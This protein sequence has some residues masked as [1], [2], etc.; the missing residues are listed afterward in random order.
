MYTLMYRWATRRRGI[1]RLAIATHPSAASIYRDLLQFEQLG[2]VRDYQGLKDAPSMPLAVEIAP[3]IAKMRALFDRGPSDPAQPMTNLYRFFVEDDHPSITLP[4]GPELPPWG[5]RDLAYFIEQLD[6][7][8]RGIPLAQAQILLGHYP[9]L[10]SVF[11]EDGRSRS[12]AS[13]MEVSR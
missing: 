1:D 5:K 4:D 3:G 2:P 8:P 12:H 10:R 11:H 6:A 13:P 7:R 9:T